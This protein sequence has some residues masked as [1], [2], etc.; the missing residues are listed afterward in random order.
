MKYRWSPV[1]RLCRSRSRSPHMSLCYRSSSPLSMCGLQEEEDL[2]TTLVSATLQQLSSHN[3]WCTIILS[4]ISIKQCCKYLQCILI[5][6]GCNFLTSQFLP[7]IAQQPSPEH[8]RNLD[9]CTL[10]FPLL[11]TSSS[12]TL[13]HKSKFKHINDFVF[14]FL[15]SSHN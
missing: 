5:I 12:L 10:W 7:S 14:E 9:P 8:S 6:I 2:H 11:T 13:S 15:I 4:T 1:D 3:P